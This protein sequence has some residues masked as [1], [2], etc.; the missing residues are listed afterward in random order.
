MKFVDDTAKQFEQTLVISQ[1]PASTS[2]AEAGR[3]AGVAAATAAAKRALIKVL[4]GTKQGEQILLSKAYTTVGT[5]G[6]QVAV[7]AKRGAHFH[8]MQ[9]SG[10]GGGNAP[11]RLNNQ[12]IGAE[13]KPLKNGDVIEVANTKLQFVEGE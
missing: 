6:I 4:N 8:L 1:P 2:H 11:P 12:P 5:P 9:M 13:S 3:P 7:I 10:V